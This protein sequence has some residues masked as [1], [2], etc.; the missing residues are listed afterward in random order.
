MFALNK[1]M[2]RDA[3]TSAA[4]IDS[5][6]NTSNNNSN[7]NNSASNDD[8][9]DDVQHQWSAEAA[10]ARLAHKKALAAA[11]RAAVLARARVREEKLPRE[12]YPSTTIASY[13]WPYAAIATKPAS[14]TPMATIAYQ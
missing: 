7:N 10:A 3:L 1:Q 5:D 11:A 2:Q 4:T 8:E 6:D 9:E 12:Y 13:L 14:S